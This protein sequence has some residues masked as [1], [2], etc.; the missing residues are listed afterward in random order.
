MGQA[1]PACD[2][3]RA[4]ASAKPFF[5]RSAEN[6]RAISLAQAACCLSN[7][8]VCSVR[9]ASNGQACSRLW[10]G[11][12]S[13]FRSSFLLVRRLQVAAEALSCALEHPNV[14]SNQ[15][16]PDFGPVRGN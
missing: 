9:N 5:G 4:E 12:H 16:W 10:L 7:A 11:T 2:C 15:N 3:L 14:V 1:V 13:R 8:I 6:L